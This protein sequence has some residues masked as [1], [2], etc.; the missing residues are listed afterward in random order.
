MGTTKDRDADRPVNAND[1]STHAVEPA[2]RRGFSVYG[3]ALS[4]ASEKRATLWL[5][6]IVLLI[7]TAAVAWLAYTVLST[8]AALASASRIADAVVEQSTQGDL[9]G[10]VDASR[11]LDREVNSAAAHTQG[12]FWN[13][14]EEFPLIGPNLI[15][16]RE[17]TDIAD[18]VSQ[19]VIV[20]LADSLVQN[21]PSVDS[22]SSANLVNIERL[23]GQIG[24]AVKKLQAG[25]DAN[26]KIPL[27]EAH[28]S[29]V[30][31]GETL[32]R[33]LS[34]LSAMLTSAEGALELAPSML[35]ATAPQ[36]YLVVYQDLSRPTAL[37][38]TATLVTELTLNNGVATV[39]RQ[40]PSSA[41]PSRTG[42]PIIGLTPSVT[43]LFGTEL[44]EEFSAS[45]NRPAWATAGLISQ[46]FWQEYIGGQVDAV[47]SI[48]AVALSHLLARTGP[49]TL[50]N[51]ERIAPETIAAQ[52]TDGEHSSSFL[53]DSVKAVLNESFAA[54]TTTANFV[55]GFGRGIAERRI[56]AWSMNAERQEAFQASPLNGVLPFDN[57]TEAAVGVF[58]RSLDSTPSGA[59]LETSVVLDANTC[60]DAAPQ[61]TTTVTVKS[62]LNADDAASDPSHPAATQVFV[63][64]PAY[65]TSAL[66]K[67]GDADKFVQSDS[68]GTDLL[69]PVSVFTVRLAPGESA[70]L[71]ATFVAGEDAIGVPSLRTT[72]LLNQLHQEV[73][74]KRC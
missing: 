53:A 68:S 9:S 62:P 20:P 32:T 28:S 30:A 56:M 11:E 57:M 27:H 29:V 3:P 66:S 74:T 7:S 23:S 58:F 33:S 34:E 2:S 15:A 63:Y 54:S 14:A 41:F 45:T 48:D 1:E 61:F 55:G 24:P 70:E 4:H 52:L 51:G 46:A 69:R 26:M 72:P 60:D 12:P 43:E 42:N 19:D 6:G 35:G 40:I 67:Q 31:G 73:K 49:L 71:K 64:G 36:T 38:G 18:S 65:S 17:M 22:S 44:A 13:L 8:T 21:S 39:G 37:G 47:V 50:S 5:I 59:A 25:V 16:I 10:I